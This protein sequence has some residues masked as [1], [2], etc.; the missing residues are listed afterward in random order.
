MTSSYGEEGSIVAVGATTD[1]PYFVRIKRS[2][3]CSTINP[4]PPTLALFSL[5]GLAL[6]TSLTFNELNSYIVKATMRLVVIMSPRDVPAC[7]YY[8]VHFM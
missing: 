4:D 8:C 6:Q 2:C 5:D 7:V 3:W 1:L